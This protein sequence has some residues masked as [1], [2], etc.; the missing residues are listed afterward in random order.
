MS[1]NVEQRLWQVVHRVLW[2]L[3]SFG[4]VSMDTYESCRGLATEQSRLSPTEDVGDHIRL[5]R[6]VIDEL[7]GAVNPR[8]ASEMGVTPDVVFIR[9]DGWVLGAPARL[10]SVA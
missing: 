8:R 3:E 9:N 10:E 1:N 4:R 7:G 5:N 2:E 6:V